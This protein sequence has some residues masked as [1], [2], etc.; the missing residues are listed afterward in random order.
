MIPDTNM[1]SYLNG[2][3]A[4][5]QLERG[6]SENTVEAYLDDAGKLYLFAGSD[7]QTLH[8]SKMAQQDIEKFLGWLVEIGIGARSQ[9]RIISGLKSFY[10]YLL[11][12]KMIS[13][14][15]M[16]LIDTPRLGRKLPMVLDVAEIDAMV[17]CIDRSKYSGERDVA[18][19][20]TL[21]GCGLRVS[22]LISLK[23]S[24]LYFHEGFVRVVGKGNKERL[25]P[26]G[27]KAIKHIHFYLDSMRNHIPIRPKCEDILFLNQKGGNLSRVYIFTML[28]DAAARAGIQKQIS[29]HTLR[30]SFATHLVEGGADLRA[31]QDMLGHASI[32]TTEIYTHL[33]TDFLRSTI[34]QFHPRSS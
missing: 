2:Y 22:E 24:Q 6:L 14:H 12:E 7:G 19:I 33:T 32:T 23:I 1:D 16:E 17:G 31:V 26:I 10:D 13:T 11:L 5:L 9:A 3:K 18:I 30:H 29:P 28:K 21:Y 27:S 4:F 25:V 34:M 8:P 20:E 15:P